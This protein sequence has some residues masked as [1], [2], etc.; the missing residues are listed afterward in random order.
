MD[1][2]DDY[3]CDEDDEVVMTMM[4]IEMTMIVGFYGI[5]SEAQLGQT[6]PIESKVC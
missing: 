3:N 1:T 5:L 2:N 6:R 4:I